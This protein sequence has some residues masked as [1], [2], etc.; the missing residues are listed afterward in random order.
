[1]KAK[2]QLKGVTKHFGDNR[3]LE[4]VDLDVMEGESVVLIGGSAAGKSLVLKCI[5]GLMTPDEGSILIDGAETVG[6]AERERTRLFDR[7]GMLFQQNALFDSLTVWEN[8]AFRLMQDHGLPAAKARDAAITKLIAVGLEADVGDLMPS[9]ISGGMQKRVG[10][11]RA[12]AA[13]PEIVLLDEPTAG[14]DPIMTNIINEHILEGVH[15]LGATTLSITSDMAG[16]RKIADRIAMLHDGRIIWCGPTE[17]V[18]NSGNPYLD[19]FIHNRA[20][21]PIQMAIT[22]A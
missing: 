18:D 9:E 12:I 6:I 17:E 2:I 13:E 1:M 20:D 11:A 8:V 7:T 5:L 14:L 10:F 15:R 19:Q 3:V 4:G 22:A 21:G 16:A